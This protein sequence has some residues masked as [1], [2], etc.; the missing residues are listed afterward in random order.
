[1][2]DLSNQD[3]TAIPDSVFALSQL[4]YLNL[5]NNFTIYPPLSAL[6]DGASGDSLNK[7]TQVP[8]EIQNLSHLR[9]LGLRGVGLNSLPPEIAQLENLDSLD[10][11]FNSNLNIA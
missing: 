5:G 3:L 4:E 8:Q 1:T 2:L 6:V 11:S 10:I 7:I 9:S